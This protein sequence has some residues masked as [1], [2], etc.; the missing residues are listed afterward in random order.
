MN[1]ARS[2]Q[3]E[4]AGGKLKFPNRRPIVELQGKT[5]EGK[6]D[7]RID[8]SHGAQALPESQA[9]NSAASSKT[10]A[11]AAAAAASSALGED[12]AQLS[13]AHVQ[14]QALVGQAL[15]LPEIRQE[16][17]QALRQAVASGKYQPSPQEVAGALLSNAIPAQL[18]A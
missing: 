17:V 18:A 6:P 1:P 5:A 10:G 2:A 13:G 9:A 4:A 7:M 16:R 15:Q 12:Q 8:S 11:G 3:R 14:I